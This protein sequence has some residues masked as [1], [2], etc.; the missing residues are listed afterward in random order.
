MLGIHFKHKNVVDRS[1]SNQQA[2]I[3]KTCFSIMFLL[4]N[5]FAVGLDKDTVIGIDKDTAI[6]LDK[7]TVIGFGVTDTR[8]KDAIKSGTKS[9]VSS[10]IFNDINGNR[11]QDDD[12]QG[13]A[14]LTVRLFDGK[15]RKEIQV[16]PDGILGTSDD[17]PGGVITDAFGV[18][19][20]ENLPPNSYRVVVTDK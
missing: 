12:D 18:Y 2:V 20:F 11:I 6:G 3:Q 19:R 8:E 7:D 9:I 4:I 16:G 13:L 1:F 10:T 15:G 14:G 17:S 5:S